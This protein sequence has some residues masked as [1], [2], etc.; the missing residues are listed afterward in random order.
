MQ[1]LGIFTGGGPCEMVGP[2][3]MGETLEGSGTFP[4]KRA[5]RYTFISGSLLYFISGSFRS[6][7]GTKDQLELL[8]YFHFLLENEGE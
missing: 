5:E 7:P 1:K 2:A 4:K 6:I 3:G 8:K